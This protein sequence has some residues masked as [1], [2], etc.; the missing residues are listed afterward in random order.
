MCEKKIQ[1]M[2]TAKATFQLH[3][4]RSTISTHLS[5]SYIVHSCNAPVLDTEVLL[6]DSYC[7]I[8]DVNIISINRE[9]LDSFSD[10]IRDMNIF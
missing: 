6:N 10:Y 1:K 3:V 5:G 8:R 7:K 4:I 9:K 2:E